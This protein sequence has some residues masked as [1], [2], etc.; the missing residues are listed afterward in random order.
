MGDK[1]SIRYGKISRGKK[2]KEQAE[3]GHPYWL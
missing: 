2:D 1:I 3:P